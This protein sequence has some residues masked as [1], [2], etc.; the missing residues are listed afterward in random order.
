MCV[1]LNASILEVENYNVRQG[2]RVSD[3]FQRGK[4]PGVKTGQKQSHLE[5]SQSTTTQG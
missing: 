5:R 2:G 4:D 3:L 1:C